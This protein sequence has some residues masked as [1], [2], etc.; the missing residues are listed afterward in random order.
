MIKKGAAGGIF[1]RQFL[2]SAGALAL[3]G[4]SG[5]KLLAQAQPATGAPDLALVNGKI[6]TMDRPIGWSRKC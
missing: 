4:L 5:A 2:G 1:R 3:G 6:H